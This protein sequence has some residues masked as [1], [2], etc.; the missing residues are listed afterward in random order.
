MRDK[1]LFMLKGSEVERYHTLKTLQT[2]TVGHHS[3]L[4]AM[5]CWLL[6]PSN[7]TLVLA[8]LMHDLAEH[9]T[10]D[11]PAPAKRKLNMSDQMAALE[12][13]ILGRAGFGVRL[14]YEEQRTLKLADCFAGML[15]CTRERA[16][17]N[18]GVEEVW[19]RY[20]SY[21]TEEHSDQVEQE[22]RILYAM[23]QLWTEAQD[24]KL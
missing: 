14:L 23:K 16:L 18:K 20:L 3:F 6:T 17:G 5:F 4:V 1:I 9:E 19:S 7:P 15:F 13:D 8:A 24:G 2:E 12:D 11:M 10:G 21:V 22:S